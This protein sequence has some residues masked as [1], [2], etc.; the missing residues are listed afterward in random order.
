MKKILTL[1]CV[2]AM[3]MAANAAVTA[4]QA[5]SFFA[6]YVDSA[7][8]YSDNITSYYLPNAK[9]VRVVMKPDGSK[10]TLTTDTKQ[11]FNQMRV[12]ANM[13]KFNK[14]KNFYTER[15][16]TKVGEDYK[17]SALRQPSTSDYKIPAYFIIG[18]DASGNLKIK[19]EMMYSKN[20][21]LLK[22][23]KK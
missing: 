11:Y 1:L 6:K 5:L 14:Y 13:A 20:Q 8:S 22:G 3:G 16:V 17:I 4:D 23:K 15:K 7:N 18:E 19:E 9:I 21:L 10:V 12:G 2:F